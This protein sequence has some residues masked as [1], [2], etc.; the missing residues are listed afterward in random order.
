M[1]FVIV[2]IVYL[3]SVEN[4]I[5][6]MLNTEKMYD[7]KLSCMNHL[8]KNKNKLVEGLENIF[9][10]INNITIT[11]VDEKQA[12]EFK[13]QNDKKFKNITYSN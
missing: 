12:I 2:A 9:N 8:E 5:Q 6:V 10:N 11:C 1:K 7:S 4:N 13:K 3:T